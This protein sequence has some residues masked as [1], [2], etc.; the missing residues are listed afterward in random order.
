MEWKIIVSYFLHLNNNNS[1]FV[2]FNSFQ[3]I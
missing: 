1:V 3:F 2:R